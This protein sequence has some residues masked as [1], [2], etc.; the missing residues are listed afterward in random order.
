MS[1]TRIIAGLISVLCYV[2][3]VYVLWDAMTVEVVAGF[4]LVS[5]GAITALIS[6]NNEF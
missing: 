6:N 3:A 1:L 4:L 2:G 5:G